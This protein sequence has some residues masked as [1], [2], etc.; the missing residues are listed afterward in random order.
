MNVESLL[1]PISEETPCGENLRWDRRFLE[2]ERLAEGKEETQFSAA[3]EP[4]WREVRDVA[5][6]LFARGKHL[7]VAVILT[8]A[9]VRLEGYPGLRDGLKLIHGLLEQHWDGIFPQLD[10]EDNNDPTE[11]V[12]SLSPLST[13][14]ATYGDKLR[15]VDRVQQATLCQSRQLGSFSLRDIALAAGTQ[16][17]VGDEPVQ[18]LSV[19]DAAFVET[20]AEVLEQIAKAAEEGLDAIKAIEAIFNDKCGFGIGPDTAPLQTVLK[21]AALQIRRRQGGEA[22][23]EPSVGAEPGAPGA[24]PA[25]ERLSGEISSGDDVLLAVEKI[26]RYYEKREPSS[27]V[28][29]VARCVKRFVGKD[30]VEITS[31]LTP[32]V[33]E[34]LVRISKPPEESSE[35][36]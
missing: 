28:P 23:E 11:R 12:N 14:P 29:L 25:G 4:D 10:V 31:V 22:G 32:D 35:S 8:L 27:P 21:D 15:L 17:A 3:E 20:D 1:R 9:A 26:C 36:S 5:N 18:T 24:A 6:E 16:E 2:L 30:F 19:I 13:P 33:I 34:T 7:R